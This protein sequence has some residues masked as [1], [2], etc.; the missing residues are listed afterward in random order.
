[1]ASSILIIA[2]LEEGHLFPMFGLAH[3]L[4]GRGHRVSIAS[5]VDNR[6]HIEGQGLVFLP[7][8]E[9]QY[10]AGSRTSGRVV[11]APN[12]GSSFEMLEMVLGEEIDELFRHTRPDIVVMTTFLSLEALLIYYRF[13][14]RAVLF[15]PYLVAGHTPVSEAYYKLTR[16]PIDKLIR[17][18]AFLDACKERLDRKSGL[19]RFMEVLAGSWELIAC[20]AEL[21][22]P[23]VQRGPCSVHTGPALR[24]LR[25]NWPLK[26]QLENI[27]QEKKVIYCSMGSQPGRLG[28]RMDHLMDVLSALM[29]EEEMR[30]YHLVVSTGG[31]PGCRPQGMIGGVTSYEWAPQRE[32]LQLADLAIIHGGLGAVKECICAGVP[33]L[34]LP[35][36]YDQ[37]QNA[38]KIVH[39]R[40]GLMDELDTISVERLMSLIKA[41]AGDHEIRERISGMQEIF[42]RREQEEIG[43]RVLEE[44]LSGASG[45][46]D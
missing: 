17:C 36:G 8:L 2:D 9:E 18:F 5:V 38:R 13:G 43:I 3:S 11:H 34:V 39:H 20:P 23:G 26:E 32:I 40:L 41:I 10:P 30:G 16:Q 28:Q 35:D 37:P 25:D 6:E 24:P 45:D 14:T 31:H 22:L 4:A 46:H 1:M 12:Q 29:Q 15:T 42:L 44:I 21:E 7:V 33:M 19:D 27:R